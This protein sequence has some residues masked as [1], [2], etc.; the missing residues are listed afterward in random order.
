MA[1]LF[2][3]AVETVRALPLRLRTNWPF[4]SCNSSPWF[5]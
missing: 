5:S 1:K 2:E 3:H 4:C